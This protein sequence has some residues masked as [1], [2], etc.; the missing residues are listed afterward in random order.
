MELGSPYQITKMLGELY[1]NYFF[2]Q[3]GIKVVKARFFNSFG[4]GEVPGRYRNVIPNFIYWALQGKPLPITGSGEETRDF[5]YVGDIVQGLLQAANA[6]AAVGESFNL[7][8]GIET[9]VIDLANMINQKTGNSGRH[10]PSSPA[11]LGPQ[12]APAGFHRE[13]RAPFWLSPP[14]RL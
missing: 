3:Y 2:K 4:P 11:P 8:S 7:G 6:D 10:P 5:T 13:G 12:G 1:C 9:K 14:N